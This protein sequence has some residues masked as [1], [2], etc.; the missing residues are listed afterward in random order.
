MK[1]KEKAKF[2]LF[3]YCLMDNHVHLLIKENEKIG[4]SIKRIAVGYVSWH[5]NKYARAGHL[6]QNRFKSEVVETESYLLT[7]LR[8]IHQ[9]PVKAKM[10]KSAK[11]FAWSSFKQYEHFYQNKDSYID[12]QIIRYYLKTLTDFESYMN[13]L[14]KDQCLEYNHVKKYSD[15]ELKDMLQKENIINNFTEI[16]KEERDKFLK[17]IYNNTGASIRQLERVLGIGKTIIANAVK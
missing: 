8:Y 1:A 7:V 15:N 13:A 11:Q 6:F 17:K 10:V 12:G 14:N 5:N 3:G 9:N 4:I 16:P 2:E